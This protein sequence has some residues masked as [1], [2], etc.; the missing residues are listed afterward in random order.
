M[1]PLSFILIWICVA[2][3]LFNGINNWLPNYVPEQNFWLVDI[4]YRL[5]KSIGVACLMYPLTIISWH[6]PSILLS[7]S[8]LLLAL[9][10]KK[11]TWHLAYKDYL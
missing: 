7:V 9:G 8:L 1:W 5:C 10:I 3:S 4:F 2:H 6:R 11:L